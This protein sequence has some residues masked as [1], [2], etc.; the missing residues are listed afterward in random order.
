V[1]TGAYHG[2]NWAA[3]S[4][5]SKSNCSVKR[6]WWAHKDSNLGPAD[7][8]S[9]ALSTEPCVRT[10]N[11]RARPEPV[12]APRSAGHTR[13]LA[14][15]R[16]ARRKLNEYG[17]WREFRIR[18]ARL[19]SLYL[20]VD[21]ARRVTALF[22]GDAERPV[23]R[24]FHGARGLTAGSERS[25]R[26]RA[27]GAGIEVDRAVDDDGL[28]FGWYGCGSRDDRSNSAAEG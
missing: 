13:S 10:R 25:L 18:H 23:G 21:R 14:L 17:I 11:C 20:D 1:L 12:S 28:R 4:R 2:A 3:G 19:R 27:F 9:A 8:E 5:L 7:Q 24:N 26:Q 6:I 16:P 15:S 22:E